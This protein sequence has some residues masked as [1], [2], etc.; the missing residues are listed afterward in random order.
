MSDMSIA[1][2]AAPAL[3][4]RLRIGLLTHSLNPR[5][6]VVHTVELA[7]ALHDAGHEVTIFAPALDH[8]SMFRTLRCGLVR[9]PIG[10]TPP[11]V[12]E[13]VRLRIDAFERRLAE[14]LQTR[15]FDVLH[16]QD[17][18]GANALANLQQRGLVGGFVRTVHHLEH[19][20][21]PVVMAWQQRGFQAASQVLCVSELWRGVLMSDHGV[22]ASLVH[23]GVDMQRFGAKPAARD[24]EVVAKFGLR[25]DAPMFLAVGGIE[26]RKN[27]QRILEAFLEARVDLPQSQLVI[28]GGASLLDHHDYAERFKATV[29]EAGLRVGPGES[30]VLTGTVLDA[31]MPSLFRAA[32]ALLLPSLSEGFG[33]VVLEALASGTPVVVSR[34]APFTEYLDGYLHDEAGPALASPV[35]W[36][37]PAHAGSIAEAMRQ[38]VQPAR[39]ASLAAGSPAVCHRFNWPA[40][41]AR[42]VA[43]Y[44]AARA[45]A[46][47]TS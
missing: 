45:L 1:L 44:R 5:G 20:D 9:V 27:T 47:S 31:D 35:C 39:A 22:E 7:H 19:F 33:L 38:V 21:D 17:P 25:P 28:A 26:Q 34:I 15:S 32:D 40:S 8:Q 23:N 6:G 43:L 10:P 16:A 13:M 41:A 46:R 14:V 30:L 24:A 42:H 4:P 37:D 12:A 29:A 2:R 11:H 18:I 3:S 36:A